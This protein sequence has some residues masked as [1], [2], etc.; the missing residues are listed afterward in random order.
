MP[1][2]LAKGKSEDSAALN[3]QVNQLHCTVNDIGRV[4]VPWFRCIGLM[5]KGIS[6]N[7]QRLPSLSV[8]V[9][10][11]IWIYLLKLFWL[12]YIFNLANSE[13]AKRSLEGL[14]MLDG[15]LEQV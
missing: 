3:A 6:F 15:P 11:L 2:A 5:T 13:K 7:F 12:R 9:S 10:L 8:V 4:F 1:L 14:R